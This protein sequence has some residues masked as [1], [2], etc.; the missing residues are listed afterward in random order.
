MMMMI[1]PVILL[2]NSLEADT[3]DV[4]AALTLVT[5]QD[6]VRVVLPPALEAAAVLALPSLVVLTDLA[7]R[8]VLPLH[9]SVH[10]QLQLLR[11]VGKLEGDLQPYS[12]V[13]EGELAVGLDWDLGT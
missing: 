3:L 4:H 12:L 13:E 9:R 11:P 8:C 2:R 10:L 7:L 5:D 1:V 6:A